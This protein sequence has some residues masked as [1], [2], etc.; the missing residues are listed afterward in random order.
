VLQ[1]KKQ[2]P[3]E[4]SASELQPA[5]FRRQQSTVAISKWQLANCK[6]RTNR[7]TQSNTK[8]FLSFRAKRG[9]CC[10]CAARKSRFL[11]SLGMTRIFPLCFCV[12]EDISF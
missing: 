9:T 8:K 6:T 5:A 1:L 3:I 2:Q 11:A 10:L 4:Q 12:L 7:K